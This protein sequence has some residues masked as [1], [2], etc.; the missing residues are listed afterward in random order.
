MS[1]D[2]ESEFLGTRPGDWILLNPDPDEFFEV[3]SDE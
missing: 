1:R 2:T 3:E